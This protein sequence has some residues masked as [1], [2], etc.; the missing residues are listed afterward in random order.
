M[1]SPTTDAGTAVNSS[2]EYRNDKEQEGMDEDQNPIIFDEGELLGTEVEAL[3]V[4]ANA[5]IW[6]AK[7]QTLG[8]RLNPEKWTPFEKLMAPQVLAAKWHNDSGNPNKRL[9]KKDLYDV[10]IPYDN[11]W[12]LK[13]TPK[14]ENRFFMV[15]PTLR[16]MKIFPLVE[17]VRREYILAKAVSD[18]DVEVKYHMATWETV[19][20]YWGEGVRFFVGYWRLNP[21]LCRDD[22]CSKALSVAKNTYQKHGDLD[23]YLKDKIQDLKDADE[24]KEKSHSPA[25]ASPSSSMSKAGAPEEQKLASPTSL[26]DIMQRKGIPQDLMVELNRI[27]NF[28]KMDA[29]DKDIIVVCKTSNKYVAF[30]NMYA[31]EKNGKDLQQREYQILMTY[32]NASQSMTLIRRTSSVQKRTTGAGL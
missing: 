7:F 8:I 5:S 26:F 11:E 27:P 2:S 6:Q 25:G 3:P 12:I 21:E 9:D 14:P 1:A 29:Y 24:K 10:L 32:V 15:P 16:D 23:L 20:K 18:A 31:S 17:N 19:V 28:Q 30:L 13:G 22:A 4:P